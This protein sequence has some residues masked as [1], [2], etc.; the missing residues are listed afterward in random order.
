MLLFG[1]STTSMFVVSIAPDFAL[2]MMF[3]ET[4]T[5]SLAEVFVR[6]WGVL[7]GVV[8]LM[9]IYGA[10]NDPVRKLVLSVAAVG[11]LAFLTLL[12]TTGDAYLAKTAATVVFD[13]L[14]VVLFTLYIMTAKSEPT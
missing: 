4:L 5:G 8:G 13:G 7:V 10:F 12:L 2:K 9:L 14:A 3:G 11:K 6:S 1:S